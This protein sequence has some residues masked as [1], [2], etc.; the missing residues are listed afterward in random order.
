ME[1][2]TY[3]SVLSIAGSDPSGGAGIQADIKTISACGCYAS[4]AIV[5]VV[6]ENTV[7]VTGVHPVP[8]GSLDVLLGQS[9]GDVGRHESVLSHNLWL[10]P[11]THRVVGAERHNVAHTRHTL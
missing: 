5:A 11:Y 9:I 3:S 4:T 10:E 6:D 7:G 8:Q 1:N 2:S